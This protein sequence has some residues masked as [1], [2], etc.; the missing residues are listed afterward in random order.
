MTE[1]EI[2]KRIVQTKQQLNE[3]RVEL[4]KLE[5][6]QSFKR[7]A[8][9]EK[10]YRIREHSDSYAYITCVYEC[11]GSDDASNYANNNYFHSA[12]RASE[13]LDKIKFLLKIERLHD[14]YCPEYTPNFEADLP[15]YFILYNPTNKKYFYSEAPYRWIQSVSQVYFPSA[16]I[17]K[18]VCDRLNEEVIKNE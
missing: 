10:Y 18:K 2:M 7:V 9:G 17:A 16:E 6:E 13:V 8:F 14:N 15:K 1:Q 5:N 12:E 11:L 3:L 4:E